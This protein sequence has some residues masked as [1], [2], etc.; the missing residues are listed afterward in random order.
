MKRRFNSLPILIFS[1]LAGLGGLGLRLWLFRTGMDDSG[2]LQSGHPATFA[3]LGLSVCVVLIVL[4]VATGV[5]RDMHYGSMR[6]MRRASAIGSFL[7]ALGTV[8][9]LLGSSLPLPLQLVGYA[10]SIVFLYQI[11]LQ[12]K[13]AHSFFVCCAISVF[14]I[15]LPL[16]QYSLWCVE[17]QLH[18]YGYCIL[19]ALSLLLASYHRTEAEMGIFHGKRMVFFSA[20]SLFFGITCADS[21]LGPLFVGIALW[22]GADLIRLK[23]VVHIRMSLPEPV[24]ECI[25]TLVSAG[26]PAY[27]VGGCVRDTLLG[28]PVQDYDLCTSATPEQIASVFSHYPLVRKGEKHG[29]IGVIIDHTVYE[30]TTFRTEG[31]YKNNRHPAW[32]SFVDDLQQDLQRRDFTVNAMAY[33]PVI[34]LQD[35]Y[36]GRQDL[37]K[38]ILRAVGDPEQ[39][40]REDSLRILRGIRFSIRFGLTP[41]AKT[42]RAMNTLAPLLDNLSRERVFDEMCKILLTCRARDLLRFAPVFA[43]AVPELGATLGF[44]QRSPHHAYDVYTHTAYVVENAPATL[45]MR[46]AALLHDIGKPACFTQDENGRGHFYGHAEKSAQMANEVLLRL[47]A[48][49]ALREQVVFLIANHMLPLPPDSKILRRKASHFGA[50]NLLALIAL[51]RADYAGKGIIED[52]PPFALLEA[53]VDNLIDDGVCLHL[54]D[55]AINGRDLLAVGFPE[56]KVLGSCLSY[57]LDCVLDG[58]LQNNREALLDA[59]LLYLQERTNIL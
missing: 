31:D 41:D 52:A 57:L 43:Q 33:S 18:N 47:K 34:G 13:P 19:A 40:F 42:G 8:L 6:Y 4:F 7:A 27:A 39:R 45:P 24:S 12:K 3:L 25:R 58:M 30:I 15:V 23:P 10:I 21:A 20:T 37:K 53:L 50:E 16:S 44:H 48:P 11:T 56:G 36:H 14:L 5:P 38:R 49:N 29:T 9:A 28:V 55:L 54:K 46:W 59:A 26:F 51:Q 32:V 17:T 35:P 2:L 22:C 1:L